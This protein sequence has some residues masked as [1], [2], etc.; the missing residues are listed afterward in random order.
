MH[1]FETWIAVVCCWPAIGSD[2]GIEAPRFVEPLSS[3][4]VL[5][6]E[7]V[8]FTVVVSG[9]PSP[10][11]SWRHN[12]NDVVEGGSPYFEV[13]RSPDGQRHSLRIGEV[14]ADDAGTVY[15]TAQNEA[16]AVSTSATLTVNSQF[17]DYSSVN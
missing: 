14:F 13:I 1:I 7:A 17:R 10:R 11:V 6:G 16:G 12:D 15:V 8:C 3:L 9:R 2:S 4:E 5:E